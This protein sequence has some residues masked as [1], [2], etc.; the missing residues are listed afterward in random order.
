MRLSYKTLRGEGAARY[1]EKRSVFIG[2]ARPAASEDE[3][4]EFIAEV[5]QRHKNVSH[6]VYAYLCGESGLQKRCSDAG[7]PQGTAGV[8]VLEVIEKSDLTDVAIVVTRYYGGIKLGA[9]GL[10]RAYGKTASLAVGAAGIVEKS[11]ARR[12]IF[13]MEYPLLGIVR[14]M[15][16]K[17]GYAISHIGYGLDI[18]LTVIAPYAE[19]DA[20]CDRVAELT[21]GAAVIE[22]AGYLYIDRID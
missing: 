16:D 22:R 8:P 20:L 19:A 18:E 15:L 9:A 7:E 12:L 6:H 3:A 21:A 5:R 14:N 17:S 2:A 13:L 4:I 1:E 11:L 10:I